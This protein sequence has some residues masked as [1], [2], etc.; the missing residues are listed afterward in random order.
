MN[1]CPCGS[2]K[3]YNDCC[4]IYISGKELPDSP[5]ALMRSRYTAYAQINIDYIGSTMK[6]PALQHFNAD[7]AREWAQKLTWEGLTVLHSKTLGAKGWVE[8]LAKYS[9]HGHHQS[10]HELSEFMLENGKWYYIDGTT[11][12]VGR[13]DLCFCGSGKKFKKCCMEVK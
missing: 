5:E 13:N 10:L 7:E 6:G 9:V 1:T 3:D 11:P 8:F 4:G 12:K 2:N